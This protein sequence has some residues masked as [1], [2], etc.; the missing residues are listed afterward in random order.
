MCIHKSYLYVSVCLCVCTLM[1]VS[2]C[3][4]TLYESYVCVYI[5]H[6]M[7]VRDKAF[8]GKL[9]K[10]SNNS[11]RCI[12]VPNTGHGH[13]FPTFA[14]LHERVQR[15]SQCGLRK[16]SLR[17]HD[18][19]HFSAKALRLHCD[20]YY[21]FHLLIPHLPLDHLGHLLGNRDEMMSEEDLAAH[22][23][24][25]ANYARLL[26]QLQVRH[27]PCESAAAGL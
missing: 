5:C 4:C 10:A 11:A 21:L 17:S 19:L 22:M 27:T 6:C 9:E 12:P 16:F 25:A 8:H 20:R 26:S 13:L 3:V 14:P 23:L 1:C 18:W 15:R 2:V 24:P 7:C